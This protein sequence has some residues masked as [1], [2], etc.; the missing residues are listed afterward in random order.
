M[1]NAVRLEEVLEGPRDVF[2]SIIAAEGLDLFASLFFYMS[3]ELLKLSED[4]M[5]VPEEINKHLPRRIVDE[6]EEV[7]S[8]TDRRLLHRTAH[9]R[10]NEFQRFC[11][12]FFVSRWEGEPVVLPFDA[13]LAQLHSLAIFAKLQAFHQAFRR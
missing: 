9:V 5:L 8:A 10:V 7:F 1:M 6:S 12:F 13:P 2:S 3:L 11:C 4:F